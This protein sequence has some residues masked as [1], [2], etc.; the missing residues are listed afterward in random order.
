VRFTKQTPSPRRGQQPTNREANRHGQDKHRQTDARATGPTGIDHEITENTNTD[1][2]RAFILRL[3]HRFP[4]P[5]T[6]PGT[7]TG[8]ELRHARGAHVAHGVTGGVL[9]VANTRGSRL[10]CKYDKNHF[11]TALGSHIKTPHTPP[12]HPSSGSSSMSFI[13]FGVPAPDF[14]SVPSLPTEKN[15]SRTDLSK[16]TR[17]ISFTTQARHVSTSTGATRHFCDWE[18]KVVNVMYWAMYWTMYGQ[19]VRVIGPNS[20]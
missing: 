12:V 17:S 8:A 11:N 3:F 1:V 19:T 10:I 5:R 20:H 2:H 13:Q 9:S 16:P 6:R 14:Q 15:T 4:R 7:A 18:R